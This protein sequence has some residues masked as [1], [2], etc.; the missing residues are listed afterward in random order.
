MT[1]RELLDA[2]IEQVAQRAAEIVLERLP[3][4]DTDRWFTATQAASYL[5]V[6]PQRLYRD[7]AIPHH[8]WGGR[9]MYRRSEIDRALE[10]S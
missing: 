9:R 3:E 8:T 1:E 5:G 4:R 6:S 10:T 2:L 7:R